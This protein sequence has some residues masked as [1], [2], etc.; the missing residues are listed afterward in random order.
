M[1]WFRRKPGVPAR[2]EDVDPEAAAIMMEV[3]Q[4]P[5]ESPTRRRWRQVGDEFVPPRRRIS[6][7]QAVAA[8]QVGRNSLCPCQS[9]R[10]YKHCCGR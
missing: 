5:P 10:K 8:P 3:C 7:V 4:S 6:Q 1:K 2:Y 9:G